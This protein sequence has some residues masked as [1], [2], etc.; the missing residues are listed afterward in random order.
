MFIS[1]KLAV[2]DSA[3][4]ASSMNIPFDLLEAFADN[5]DALKFWSELS[6]ADFIRILKRRFSLGTFSNSALHKILERRAPASCHLVLAVS[7]V[8]DGIADLTDFYRIVRFTGNLFHRGDFVRITGAEFERGFLKISKNGIRK[9]FTTE[10]LKINFFGFQKSLPPPTPFS[11]ACEGVVPVCTFLLVRKFPVFFSSQGNTI[12]EP[13]LEEF[14]ELN[15][16][17]NLRIDC[18]QKWIVS[19][20]SGS[21]SAVTISASPEVFLDA[22]E[23]KVFRLTNS[24]YRDSAGFFASRNCRVE[25]LP[26]FWTSRVPPASVF[27]DLEISSALELERGGEFS[28]R[29]IDGFVRLSLHARGRLFS[30]PRFFLAA[31]RKLLEN[32]EFSVK[33]CVQVG[34]GEFVADLSDIEFV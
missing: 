3:A 31:R 11:R 4:L 32:R 34:V 22:K 29:L 19:D 27:C 14:C 5:Y 12:L 24:N 26:V 13:A 28:V 16:E 8:K 18:K 6:G 17:R 2:S 21:F 30:A 25:V 23:G 7:S 33:N 10:K 20:F 1:A 15:G 9:V